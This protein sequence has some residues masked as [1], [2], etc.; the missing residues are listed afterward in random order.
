MNAW[1]PKPGCT[2][3][4]SSRSISS[5]Y[6]STVS[7]GVSGLSVS[8]TP[9]PSSRRSREQR[10]GVAELDVHGA[11]V[12]AGVGEVVEQLT[13][14]VDHEVAVEEEVG[15]LAQRLHDGRADREVGHE[16]A[17]HHVDVEQVGLGGDALDLVAEPREVGREDR[18]RDLASRSRLRR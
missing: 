15:A 17:V 16:V 3:M 12:G 9:T 7:T 11:A 18:R 5:R 8:P 14:V 13:G 1:P 2:L 6:G 10:A 4:N